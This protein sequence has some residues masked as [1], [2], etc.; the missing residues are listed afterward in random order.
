MSP[1]RQTDD[2]NVI[3]TRALTS[4]REIKQAVPVTPEASETVYAGR[5]AIRNI[6]SRKD[7]RMLIVVGP[8]SIHDPEA[9][10]EYAERLRALAGEL[11]DRLCIVMRTYF[12]KPRTTVG[13]KGFIND[14]RLDGSY[15]FDEGLRKAREILVAIAEMGLP[16]A[17][18][19]LEPIVP[20][21]IA[22]LIAW[23]S[24][25]ARTIESQTHREMASGL[26]M[27]VG[28]KNSTDGNLQ[29]AINAVLA[30]RRPHH[31]LGIDQD[32]RPSVVSTRGN[33]WGHIILRG[34]G[35]RPNYDPVSV[36]EAKDMLKKVGLTTPIMVDC[37]HANCG[38]RYELQTHVLK[39]VIQQR[40]EHSPALMG[41]MLESNLKEGCQDFPEAGA[42]LEYGLSV[43]DPCL[44]WED[45]A[46]VLRY[47]YD[48][49]RLATLPIS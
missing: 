8:C 41:L 10:L 33:L 17:T 30:S 5:E 31:F 9:T 44:G 18:E 34:G 2:L 28:F 13:W 27:P 35:G 19:M 36:A 11:K 40:L 37:S 22:D 4:P 20:Q 32:G 1:M 6:L 14:P 43:T 23:A 3:G 25:G 7:A 46:S 42:Q 38:K 48:R 12:E 29:I 26:S 21:Y 45:T 49:L 39:D 47:A 15:D 16:T 24:I